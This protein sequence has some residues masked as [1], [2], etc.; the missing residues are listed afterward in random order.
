MSRPTGNG[1]VNVTAALING[2]SSIFFMSS[3]CLI[4]LS[5]SAWLAPLARL[6]ST[7]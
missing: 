6:S 1:S 4:V 7:M 2:F 3:P 5:I